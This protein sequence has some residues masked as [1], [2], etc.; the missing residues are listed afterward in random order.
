MAK[1]RELTFYVVNK[2]DERSYSS[3]MVKIALD[4]SQSILGRRKREK[5]EESELPNGPANKRQRR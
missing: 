3:V 4:D 1:L 2:R 5:S